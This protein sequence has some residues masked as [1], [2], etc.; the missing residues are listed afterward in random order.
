MASWPLWRFR[1]SSG[2][3]CHRPQG[4][5]SARRLADVHIR[6]QWLRRSLRRRSRRVVGSGHAATVDISSLEWSRTCFSMISHR[7]HLIVAA[8]L[9]SLTSAPQR[10]GGT[11]RSGL[12]CKPDGWSVGLW[13]R[14]W[15]HV[16]ASYPKSISEAPPDRPGPTLGPYRS[17]Q[18][19]PG[20]RL[21][22]LSLQVEAPIAVNAPDD[23][24]RGGRRGRELEPGHSCLAWH[25][26]Y[27][28][29][30]S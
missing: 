9:T 13:A 28:E 29:I 26:L 27:A 10:G 20:N 5:S 22:V 25:H 3:E 16:G 12:I 17:R 19:L 21:A 24:S 14:T 15:C 23:P 30:Q 18:P 2:A 6:P 8:L 1:P 11:S 4:R 7:L